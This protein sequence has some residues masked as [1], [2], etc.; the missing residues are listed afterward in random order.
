M[1]SAEFLEQALSTDVDENAVNAIVGSLENQLVT[2]VPSASLQ[3]NIGNVLTSQLSNITSSANSNIGLQKYN[4]DQISNS[5]IVTGIHPHS[6]GLVNN[7]ASFNNVLSSAPSTFVS[8][9]LTGGVSNSGE[10]IKVIYSQSANLSNPNNRVAY[11][12][13]SLANGCIGLGSQNQIIQSVNKGVA[14]QP[15]LVIKQGTTTGQVGMQPGMVTVPLTV[16]SS[17]PTSIPNVMT[18]N[19]PGG[20]NVVVTTQNLGS[21][22]PAIIPNV[23]I[24]NMR[25]G[26]PAVAAQKSVATVSPRVVIG[27]PQVVGA[28]AAAPGVSYIYLICTIFMVT[29][30]GSV[31][32]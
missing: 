23:Q 14:M 2:S 11:P 4:T 6:S 12:G 20:Q 3:N 27:T 21:A 16:N 25:P 5:G 29:L 8:Q 18:L 24:L 28:R 26:A 13:Q 9:T 17:M 22:Q 1:A 7:S 31:S 19:K 15:P 10:A 30:Y 32:H